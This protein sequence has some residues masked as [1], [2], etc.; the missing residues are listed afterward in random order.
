MNDHAPSFNRD[1]DLEVC[2]TCCYLIWAW[3]AESMENL[4]K[5][6]IEQSRKIVKTRETYLNCMDETVLWDWLQYRWFGKERKLPVLFFLAKAK[7][8]SRRTEYGL[9]DGSKSNSEIARK[10]KVGWLVLTIIEDLPRVQIQT[11][12]YLIF[13]IAISGIFLEFECS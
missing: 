2:S 11:S 8:Y 9:T 1:L 4:G 6:Q 3:A 13:C 10:Y 7:K 12:K 5:T